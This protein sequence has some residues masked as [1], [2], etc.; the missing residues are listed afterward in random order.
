VRLSHAPAR[1]RVSFDDPHL[2]SHAGLVPVFSG[3][4]APCRARLPHRGLTGPGPVT[5]PHGRKASPGNRP[6]PRNPCSKP[7]SRYR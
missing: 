4:R 3:I 1:T 7:P 5:R 6:R 2:V